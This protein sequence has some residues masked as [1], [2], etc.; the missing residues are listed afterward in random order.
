MCGYDGQ[1]AVAL[2]HYPFGK[3]AGPTLQIRLAKDERFWLTMT[4]AG[5][6]CAK[7][8]IEKMNVCGI[9]FHQPE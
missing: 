2:D 7:V 3:V 8:T 6:S 4:K 9:T 1:L 5:G